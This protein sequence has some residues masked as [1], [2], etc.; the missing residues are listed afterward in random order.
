M[1][2]KKKEGTRE[3]DR[4]EGRSKDR[5]K[6]VFVF[7]AFAALG[8][9]LAYRG[10]ID[11]YRT[12]SC[13]NWPSVGGKVISSE[14]RK[15][16]KFRRENQTYRAEVR[17]RYEVDGRNYQCDKI[18]FGYYSSSSLKDA[19]DIVGKYKVGKMVV[20]HYDPENPGR[21][22]IEIKADPNAYIESGIGLAIIL[23]LSMLVPR[24]LRSHR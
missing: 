19:R 5:Y 17:Y 15:L 4:D 1:L 6:I 22:V 3:A 23:V 21:A 14:I 11:L 18:S 10:G 2:K 13:G 8:L 20:V 24:S 16:H 7:I 9:F 12:F